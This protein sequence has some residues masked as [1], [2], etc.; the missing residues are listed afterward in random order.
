MRELLLVEASTYHGQVLIPLLEQLDRSGDD[1][2]LWLNEEHRD[3]DTVTAR[4]EWLSRTVWLPASRWRG[5]LLMARR[6]LS[7]RSRAALLLSP[8]RDDTVHFTLLALL[9]PNPAFLLHRVMEFPAPRAPQV[10]PLGAVYLAIFW[11][12]WS[13]KVKALTLA[14]RLARKLTARWSGQV[15][16]L[17]AG[18]KESVSWKSLGRDRLRLFLPG[19]LFAQGKDLES[20]LEAHRLLRERGVEVTFVV[21]GGNLPHASTEE[22][23]LSLRGDPMFEWRVAPW[24]CYSDFVSLASGCHGALQLPSRGPK[25]DELVTSVALLAEGLPRPLVT[26]LGAGAALP[27]LEYGN[28]AQMADRIESL[29]HLVQSGGWHELMPSLVEGAERLRAH[30][31]RVLSGLMGAG[32]SVGFLDPR[33]AEN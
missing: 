24:L 6:L 16:S 11:A 23:L 1:W 4:P 27:W 8:C 3:R 2:T 26:P 22:S 19:P 5:A 33:E 9:H 18:S 10:G 12:L 21:A 25:E 29:A 15:Y 7:E 28:A 30:S 13:G 31:A 32:P 14:P 20:L 17:G